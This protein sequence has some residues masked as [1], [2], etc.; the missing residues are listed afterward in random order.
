MIE[1][2][3][4]SIILIALLAASY[5]DLKTREVPDW[6]S[7]GLIFSGF[8]LNT[9][10]SIIST[11]PMPLLSSLAGF[12]IAFSFASLMYY[13]GQWGG[14][15]SKL[16]MGVGAMMGIQFQFTPIPSLFL[17]LINML[18]AGAL[19][20]IGWIAFLGIKNRAKLSRELPRVI[21]ATAS[22]RNLPFLIMIIALPFTLLFAMQTA[23]LSI[24]KTVALIFILIPFALIA[25]FILIKAIE[26]ISF[27]KNIPPSKL[28]EGD[29]IAKPI[30]IKN[31]II[32]S[33]K[34][35][36]I[37]KAQIKKL[38]ALRIKSVPIK[39]GIPF[40]PSFLFG[41]L[42]TLVWG[43]WLTAVRLL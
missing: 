34:D 33:P 14:G 2:I 8:G 29:W 11:D 37:S 18:L 7:Y 9:L 40:V 36:G 6:L 1:I 19:Y 25:L 10:Y 27:Y 38:I 30:K 32:A 20:G 28:T 24:T 22:L 42:A 13:T 16:L 4:F 21:S 15:D 5:T 26:H 31:R 17:F 41:F 43:D 3:L 23:D 39:E 12:A 35:L